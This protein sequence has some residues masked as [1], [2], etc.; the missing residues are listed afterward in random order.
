MGCVWRRIDNRI[1][2]R[3][4]SGRRFTTTPEDIRRIAHKI[5]DAIYSRLT[6]E[7][8]Y[9]DTHIYIAENISRPFRVRWQSWMPMALIE[10]LTSGTFTVLT[11]RFSPT[12]QQITYMSYEGGMPRVYLYDLRHLVR[13][14]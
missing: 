13:K 7:S 1:R 6:G 2:G 9:F 3:Q 12:A 11:P 8:G 5:A 4:V 14:C 10:Y